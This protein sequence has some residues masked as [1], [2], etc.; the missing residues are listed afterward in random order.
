[1][2]FFVVAADAWARP[3]IELHAGGVMPLTSGTASGPGAA[4]GLTLGWCMGVG[5]LLTVQ[6]EV[7]ARTNLAAPVTVLGVGGQALVGLKFLQLGP[8]ARLGLGVGGS[9]LPTPEAGLAI[10][11]DPPTPLILG[12]RG[13]WEFDHPTQFKCGDCPQPAEQWVGASAMVGVRL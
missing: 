1:M 5:P 7:Y 6:P 9:S 4:G 8:Y 10:V 12:V 2:V 3:A 13:G 11:V